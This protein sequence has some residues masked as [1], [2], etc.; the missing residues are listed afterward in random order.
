METNKLSDRFSGKDRESMSNLGFN[1]MT[2]FMKLL[3][4]VGGHSRKNFKTLGLKPGQTV[5]DYG[6]GRPGTL[7]LHPMPWEKRAKCSQWTYTPLPL[8]K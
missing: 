1:A 2:L 8:P 3:D 4:I 7:D 5:I 6:C